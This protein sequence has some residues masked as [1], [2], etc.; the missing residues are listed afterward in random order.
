MNEKAPT[1]FTVAAL[2]TMLKDSIESAEP[3]TAIRA[4]LATRDG[5]KLTKADEPKLR[6]AAKND[7]IRI[8]HSYG[9]VK[10]SWKNAHNAER[11]YGVNIPKPIGQPTAAPVINMVAFDVSNVGY[12]SAR[13][14]RNAARA[15]ALADDALLGRLAAALN[16]KIAAE[17][18][19]C[20]MFGYGEPLAS[21][22]FRV[23]DAWKVV[24]SSLGCWPSGSDR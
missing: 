19:L 15:K 5:K 22:E 2:R 9:L 14:E 3:Q 13:E 4:Y 10:I 12:F 24:V 6:A 11:A 21:I 18:E 7:S 1:L 17:R 16:A 20:A 23:K 8:D